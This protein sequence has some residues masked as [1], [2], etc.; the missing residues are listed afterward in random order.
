MRRTAED[1]ERTTKLIL[2]AAIE[3]FSKNSYESV[4]MQDIADA[5][6]VSRGP[7][8]YRYKTKAE[9]FYAAYDEDMKRQ[10]AE[11]RRIFSQNKSIFDLVSEDMAYC[12]SSLK[13]DGLSVWHERATGEIQEKL[14]EKAAEYEK[15]V[16][17]I[18]ETAF[19][20]AI[21]N[22]ELK[23]DTDVRRL[24]NL[25]FIMA[26]GM[27]FL[28]KYKKFDLTEEEIEDNIKLM[29]EIMKSGYGS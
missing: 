12:T 21:E 22:G 17:A 19:R 28:I 11:Y 20:R 2:D 25:M 10:V 3:V 26:E 6:G 13:M 16:Y 15:E 29:L 14:R 27:F 24:V 1:T 4:N 7:L 8:Y 9:L 23:P 5:A 18:K